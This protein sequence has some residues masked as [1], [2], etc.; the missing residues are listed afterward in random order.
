[1]I[2]YV[3]TTLK[4][5]YDEIF[6][7]LSDNRKVESFDWTTTCKLINEAI[8]EVVDAVLPFKRI[9]FIETLAVGDLTEVPSRFISK[10]RLM[11]QV[12]G[13]DYIEARHVDI[14]EWFSLVGTEWNAGYLMQPIYSFWSFTDGTASRRHRFYIK[15]FPTTFTGILEHFAVPVSIWLPT[16][17]VPIPYEYMELVI[18]LTLERIYMRIDEPQLLQ[19]LHKEI[20]EIRKSNMMKYIESKQVK[21]KEFEN[22]IE[23]TPPQQK[24]NQ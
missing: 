3:G 16:D 14:K 9:S 19:N 12:S 23:P 24:D 8:G 10:E 2:Q 7:R 13:T 11:L 4:Q 21:E 17:I 22:Y 20:L 5:L 15:I 1:M 18:A 6:I